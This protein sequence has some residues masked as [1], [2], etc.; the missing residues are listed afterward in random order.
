VED[1]GR[2]EEVLV[3]G[4]GQRF[5][6]ALA[7]AAEEFAVEVVGIEGELEIDAAGS[8]GAVGD[9]DLI[10]RPFFVEA[11]VAVGTGAKGSKVWGMTELVT[12]V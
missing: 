11:G 8:V 7:V 1:E 4:R 2:F 10:L 5:D 9:G 3:L 12:I 6:D